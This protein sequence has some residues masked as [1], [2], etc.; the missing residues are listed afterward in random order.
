[1]RRFIS[2]VVF[3]L[4]SL[5][6][7]GCTAKGYPGPVR[8]P[9]E[10]ATVVTHATG[11]VSITAVYVDGVKIESLADSVEILPGDHVLEVSF[12]AETSDSCEK[13]NIY[14]SSDISYGSCKGSIRTQGGRS[15]LASLK[16]NHAL[17]D[18]SFLAKGYYEFS[19]RGDEP[20]AGV[21]VCSVEPSTIRP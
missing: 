18:A 4:S 9:E 21:L 14:C 15:Y 7:Q 20:D 5:W 12:R 6:V 10:V 1:M 11:A 19:V 13:Y 3:S 8:P 2:G 16:R 17:I